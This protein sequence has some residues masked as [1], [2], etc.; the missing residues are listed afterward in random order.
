MSTEAFAGL[1][2]MF[3]LMVVVVALVL[4][5]IENDQKDDNEDLK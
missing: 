5:Q 2:L 4:S 1:A 3:G